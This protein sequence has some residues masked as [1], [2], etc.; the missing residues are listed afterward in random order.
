MPRWT[1]EEKLW[2]AG[3]GL[4]VMLLA[5]LPYLFALARTPAGYQFMGFLGNPDD[6]NAHLA[7]IRQA[8]EGRLLLRNEYTTEPH[9]GRF[10]NLYFLFLGRLAAGLGLSPYSVYQGSR[11][12]GGFLL[13]LFFYRGLCDFLEQRAERKAALLLAAFSSGLGWLYLGLSL[14]PWDM[15]DVPPGLIVPEANTWLSLLHHPLFVVSMLLYWLAFWLGAQGIRKRDW[16]WIVGAWPFALTLGGVHTYDMLPLGATLLAYAWLRGWERRAWPFKE[17]LLAGGL[18]VLSSPFV[19]YQGHLLRTDPLYAA[20]ANTPTLT[21]SLPIL[22]MSLGLPLALALVGAARGWREGREGVTPLTVWLVVGL[23]VAYAPVP[24]Q[25]KMLEGIHLP[26]CALAAVGWM[27]TIGR[28]LGGKEGWRK[29]AFFL[30][31]LLTLP[32]QWLCLLE[33]WNDLLDNARSKRPFW[34]PPPYLLQAERDALLWLKENTPPEAVVLCSPL[35]GNYVPPLAGRRVYVGHWA[36]TLNFIEKQRETVRFFNVLEPW[37]LKERFLR[38][39]GITHVL[40]GEMEEELNEAY[41]EALP[42]LREV[43][44]EGQVRIFEV[45]PLR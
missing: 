4:L 2:A 41:V 26:L 34:T 42:C 27:G 36:E 29:G 15:M 5:F 37:R 39:A 18:V 11:W 25:R 24:F 43:W 17:I 44:R 7:W 28:M 22:A 38:R 12:V 35:L 9:E 31:L 21:P 45:V 20:K 32:S 16:R 33:N 1:R 6:R 3:W 8:L 19:V 30:T 40:L 14:G 13:L 10:L 23:A